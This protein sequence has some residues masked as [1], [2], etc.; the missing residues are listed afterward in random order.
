MRQI[1]PFLLLLCTLPALAQDTAADLARVNDLFNGQVRFKIDKRDRLIADFF[2]ATGHFRQDVVYVEFLAPEAF[3]F[4]ADEQVVMLRCKDDQAQCIDKEVF[5][6]NTIRHMG[7]M[8]LPLVPGDLEGKKAIEA[9]TSLVRNAQAALTAL[10]ETKSGVP[11][12]N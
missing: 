8:N 3:A 7:R 9:L 4:N 11:R 10:H 12:K 2:D 6:L 5:K 1:L